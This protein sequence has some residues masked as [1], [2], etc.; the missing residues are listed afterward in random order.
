MV[1]W[2]VI[3]AA[4]VGAAR[5]PG[6][7]TLPPSQG[8][9]VRSLGLP[10]VR[11]PYVGVSIGVSRF[12]EADLTAHLRFG[13]YRDLTLPTTGVLGIAAEGYG[14]LAGVQADGGARVMLRSNLL[15]IGAGAD[16]NLREQYVGFIFNVAFPVRRGGVL[17]RGSELRLDIL[18]ARRTSFAVGVSYPLRNAFRGVTRPPRDHVVL[19]ADRAPPLPFTVRDA[20]LESALAEVRERAVWIRRSTTPPFGDGGSPTEAVTEATRPL[21]ARLAAGGVADEIRGYHAAVRRAFRIAVEDS[22]LGDAVAARALATLLDAVVFPYN[23]LLGQKKKS[24]TTRE[25][26]GHARGV[27]AR[28]LVTQSGVHPL[29]HHL[30]LQAFQGLLDAAESVR[31]EHQRQ[32]QESRLGW[33]PLQLALSPDAYDEQQELD[34]LVS[35]AVGRRILHGNRVWYVHNQRFQIELVRSIA[36]AKEYHVLWVH[37]FAGINVRGE[38]D[39]L[40]LH[41]VA[42]AYLRAL[43]DRVTQYDSAGRLP[44]FMLFIDQHY[45]DKNR[46]RAMLAVLTDPLRRNFDL[47]A[48]FDSLEAEVRVAQEDLLRAVNASFLLSTERSL[49]GERWLRG[50]VKVHVSVT[51]PADPSFRSPWILPLIGLPDDAMRDHRK[52][53][54]WDVSEEDPYRGVAMYAGAGVGEHYVGPAWEDRAVMLQGPAALTVRDEARALLESQGVTGGSVPHVLRPRPRPADYERRVRAVI[55][56]MDRWG[57]VATRALELHNETGYAWKRINVAKATI[58][59]LAAPGSV[60]KVPD[61]LWEADFLASLLA[62]AALRGARVLLIA[63]SLASAPSRG[64]PQLAVMHDLLSR[65]LVLRGALKSAIE[66]AGGAYRLGIY[67][68]DVAVDAVSAR[69]AILRRRLAETPFLRELYRFDAAT[70]RVLD[71]AEAL[72]GAAPAQPVLPVSADSGDRPKLHFKGFLYVS[73]DAWARLVSGPAMATGMAAYLVERGRQLREGI[74]VEEEAMAAALQRVAAAAIN[75]LLDTLPLGERPR[76]AFFL[77]IGSA[78]ENYRSMLMDGE[79]MV[80]VSGW[81]SLYAVPDLVLLTGIATWIDDQAELDRRLPRPGRFTRALG[82]MGRLGL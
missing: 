2:L 64:A 26:A 32:W 61:S 41:T 28:W 54:F 51:N 80:L 31:A 21:A 18:W 23:R 35:R 12:A 38:P 47:P 53:V 8:G 37:D 13:S 79:A 19:S 25:F 30:V 42:R 82:R 77:M 48:G 52:V 4:L 66:R 68:P 1:R 74:G 73:G 16:Y 78:N 81:T 45:F 24:D 27:F 49:Y 58:F 72:V 62:G 60:I 57:G 34:S 71:S 11:R 65:V 33:L 46:S 55:D 56:S 29:R 9:R 59:N 39:R 15:R 36:Q 63:P 44:V 75:P 22:S 70:A 6:Q 10:V 76:W 17:Q 7:D 14:G 3:V 43:R 67:D 20:G 5:L 50:L 40:S 69:V